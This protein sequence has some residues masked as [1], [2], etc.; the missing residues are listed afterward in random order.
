MGKEIV[1]KFD[2]DAYREYKEL[3][4]L[5][6]EGK[7]AKKMPTYSQLLSSINTALGNIKANPYFGDLIPQKYLSRAVIDRYG[8]DKIWIVELL[9]NWRLFHSLIGTLV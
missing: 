9:V 3:Q 1:I 6:A 8:T 5:V 4:Q 7:V 2:E